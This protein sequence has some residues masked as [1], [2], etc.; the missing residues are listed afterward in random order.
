VRSGLYPVCEIF[1]GERLEV[2][3][4]PDFSRTALARYF[5]GQGRFAK[6]ELDLDRVAAG[7]ESHWR[8]LRAL[9]SVARLAPV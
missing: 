4:E 7:I 9:E 6:V 3:V 1:D 2:N 8:R 5:E